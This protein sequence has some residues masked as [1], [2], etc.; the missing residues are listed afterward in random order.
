VKPETITVADDVAWLDVNV[1]GD[2]VYATTLPDGPPVV[3]RETARLI[4]TAAAAG[5]T[6]EEIV[7]RVA[8]D[9]GADLEDLRDDVESFVAQLVTLG[10]LARH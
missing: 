7:D 1:V 8:E 5:G 10:L 2:V 6:L 9:S 3:L 4:F